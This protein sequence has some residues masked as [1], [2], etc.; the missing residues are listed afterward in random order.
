MKLFSNQFKDI[1][2][3]R[4]FTVD[5]S[6]YVSARIHI[7]VSTQEQLGRA[8]FCSRPLDWSIIV[9]TKHMLLYNLFLDYKMLMFFNIS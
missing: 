8:N 9:N 6:P 1:N 5:F 4:R 7:A 3:L 2:K